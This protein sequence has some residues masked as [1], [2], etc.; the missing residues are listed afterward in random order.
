M[1]CAFSASP[2]KRPQA[3]WAAFFY[4]FSL[5]FNHNRD[6]AMVLGSFHAWIREVL[7]MLEDTPS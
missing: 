3:Y 6:Q 2:K 1:G 4:G 7:K 5:N